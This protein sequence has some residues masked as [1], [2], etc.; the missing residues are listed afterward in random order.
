MLKTFRRLAGFVYHASRGH[1]GLPRLLRKVWAIYRVEGT[2]GI[3]RRLP[4]HR[5]SAFD[6]AR[7]R[8][9]AYHARDL[10]AGDCLEIR[11]QGSIAVIAH[12][13]YPEL[14]A[15]MAQA[16]AAIPWP[17]DLY[18]SVTS[19]VARNQ[20]LS[21]TRQLSNAARVEV[22]V[23]PNRG[24]DIAPLLVTFAAAIREHQYILH[25]HTKKSLYSGRERTEW[26]DYLLAGL[27]GSET[28]V[29]QIF[30]EFAAHPTVGIIYPDTFAGVPYWA[31]TWLQNRGIALALGARLGIDIT[32]RHYVDAPM[33][34]MFWARSGALQPLVDL[35]LGYGDFPDEQG[36]TDGT[37]QH[38]IERFFVLSAHRAGFSGRV[39]LDA[40]AG[41]TLFLS[42]GRKNLDHYFGAGTGERIL[43]LADTA[44]IVSFDIFDTL[45]VRPWFAPDNVFEFLDAE[46]ERRF[47]IADFPRLRK[48]AERFARQLSATGDVNLAEIYRAFGTLTGIGKRAKEI[49]VLEEDTEFAILRP[50]AEVCNA[51]RTLAA[52]GKR[53]VLVSDMYLDSAFLGR[54]L[55]HHKLDFFAAL[56]VSN[57]L[58][59]RKDN[60]TMWQELPRSE[61]VTPDRWLHVGDNEHSDLQ[62][63]LDAGFLHPVHVMRANDQFALFNE[64][65]SAWM[66]PQHWQEG[67]L[68]GLLANRLFLPGEA[69]T[70]IG[71]DIDN[72]S[73]EIR[74]LHDFGYLTIG[75]AL[76]VFMAWL[77]GQ[78][79]QD[80]ID[81][82]LYASREGHLLQ[83]AHELVAHQLDSS[84]ARIPAGAYF[85]CSRGAAGLAAMRDPAALEILLGAHFTGSFADLLQRRYC[86]EDLTP[87]SA[88]LGQQAMEQPGSLPE[89]RARFL[90]ML[91]QCQDLLMACAETAQE[92][93]LHYTDTLIAGRSAALVDIGYSATIQ[94]A[95]A[96][97][98]KDIAGGY[99]FVTTENAR[100]VE[101]FGQFAKGCFGD[102]INPFHSDLP[103]YQYSLLFEAVLTAPHG[104]FLG[105]DG[106]GAP[107]YKVP[108]LAQRHFEQL[109]AIHAGALGFLA[110]V[111]AVTGTAF[112]Q[113]GAHHQASQ[114]PIRQVMEYRW[115]LAGDSQALH[116]EDNFS[117]NG[118]LSIFEFYDRKRE[119]LP[120][121][122]D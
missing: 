121:V 101:A 25:I 21:S 40:A 23:T 17:F 14:F 15:P 3:L 102:G 62:R 89:D 52:S 67:L 107:R 54:L 27:L 7:F 100:G 82:L 83:Q 63:P 46:V 32:H 97:F 72:R 116:V 85:L 16:L 109:E 91:E 37:L 49:Q 110:D 24:R 47:A 69:C 106:S 111:L 103:L 50:N 112:E 29:R 99:Y 84:G 53:L 31:H 90:S 104:Q 98:V 22:R 55:A 75:P 48:E 41:A 88:R 26:R 11:P 13:Y 19:E 42:P 108:G 33:G 87:F 39:M 78:A 5:Q 79:R 105:F 61:G 34:S 45:L 59:A 96:H 118:E 51:A 70:P 35:R 120:G 20:V 71:L 60:G 36:Q 28:R 30:S 115:R 86:I 57:A 73:I 122:L 80:G 93:Y 65:A 117:G 4:L 44:H 76:T 10:V 77:I 6:A 119:R 18:V 9:D 92:R 1:G 12:A 8:R 56:Y 81:L 66:H 58:G 38:A 74:S 43:A 64:E 94:K 113:L 68:L 114:L 95:L 2:A